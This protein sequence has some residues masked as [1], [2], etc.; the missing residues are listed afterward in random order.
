MAHLLQEIESYNESGRTTPVNGL[1]S[2]FKEPT[3]PNVLEVVLGSWW[4][5]PWYPSFYPEELVGK[6]CERL[7]VCKWCF[8]YT[9]DAV[10]EYLRH[11]KTCEYRD[12]NTALG[13]PIY[14]Q[15][16]YTLHAL[17][18]E[19]HRLF[20]QNLSLFAKLFL[21]SKSVMYDVTTF[22]FYV[23]VLHE[24]SAAEPQIVG[25]FSKEKLSW[26]SNN[27]A[28][29]LVFPPWQKRGFGQVLMGVSYYLGRREGRLGGPEKP[30]SEL[31]RRA[32]VQYW[33]GVI[34][35][36]V[37]SLPKN[38]PVSVQDITESTYIVAEDVI[39]T[40]KEMGVLER[41]NSIGTGKKKTSGAV[42]NKSKIKE[43]MAKHRVNNK[44][45]VV[46]TAFDLPELS[47]EDEMEESE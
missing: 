19:E 2:K 44:S 45:P 18:G 23:L 28:C 31:G 8:K 27:L 3:E 20:A 7:Y 16:T 14:R 24:P 21:D 35:R 5:K 13:A 38:K 25:F 39:S 6:T 32:Y 10:Q 34:C 30:L 42:I 29:I 36:H 47:D 41:R 43:W 11:M 4:I 22:N 37:L 33:A 40:L 1:R 12:I 15:P 9:R 17:D 46:E 26:D